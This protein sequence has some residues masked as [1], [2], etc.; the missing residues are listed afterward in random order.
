MPAIGDIHAVLS[1][2]V[3]EVVTC[4]R[5]RKRRSPARRR[6]RRLRISGDRGRGS[7]VGRVQ[8]QLDA[9]DTS[10][11]VIP[12]R[13][14]IHCKNYHPTCVGLNTI[15]TDE[16]SDCCVKRVCADAAIESGRGLVF[17]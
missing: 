10:S 5:D 16:V 12:R 2:L 17:I 14:A 9:I 3:R 7:G 8:N 15:E 4:G 1:P 6:D 13:R 11:T